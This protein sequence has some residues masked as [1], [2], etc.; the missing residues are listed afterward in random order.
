[1]TLSEGRDGLEMYNVD[2]IIRSDE[3]DQRKMTMQSMDYDSDSSDDERVDRSKR[4]RRRRRKRR[5]TDEVRE[6]IMEK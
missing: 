3:E 5:K 2:T 6:Y 4:R 1:M